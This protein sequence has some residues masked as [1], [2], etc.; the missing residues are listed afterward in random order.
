MKYLTFYIF[1][2]ACSPVV[3]VKNDVHHDGCP[4][5]HANSTKLKSLKSSG[6]SR[7]TLFRE[8]AGGLDARL[9]CE[10]QES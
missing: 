10:Y 3:Q 6:A 1:I 5:S 8:V 2:A 9:V 7:A 4:K